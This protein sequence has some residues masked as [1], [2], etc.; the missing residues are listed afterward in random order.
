LKNARNTLSCMFF[1]TR[2]FYLTK[3]NTYR[4]LHKKRSGSCII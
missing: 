1:S 3:Y 2:F 4:L